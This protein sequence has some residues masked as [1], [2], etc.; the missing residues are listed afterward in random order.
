MVELTVFISTRERKRKATVSAPHN[1]CRRSDQ[2]WSK[3]QTS[4]QSVDSQQTQWYVMRLQGSPRWSEALSDAEAVLWHEA[5]KH[6]ATLST[7]QI[8]LPLQSLRTAV[9]GMAQDLA[10]FQQT[11]RGIT[12]WFKCEVTETSEFLLPS[13][14][15]KCSRQ[16]DGKGLFLKQGKFIG[17]LFQKRT[18][19][20]CS[21]RCCQKSS[22]KWMQKVKS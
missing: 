14:A 6:T 12:W 16:W 10:W 2:I 9:T 20:R 21:I 19:M 1:Q 18:S 4:K 8:L 3:E 22:R 13:T 15:I 5:T 7:G 11:W 17:N